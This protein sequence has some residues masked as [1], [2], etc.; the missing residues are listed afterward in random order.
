MAVHSMRRT[1]NREPRPGANR[2]ERQRL[3][4]REKIFEASLEEFRREGFANA[5]IDRIV[6]QAG[7]ARG[8]FYFHFPTKEHV[9]VEAQ[10]RAEIE[11]VER[12]KALGPPP[13][14][15]P[16]FLTRVLETIV[17]SFG[18]DAG[19]RREVLTMYQRVNMNLELSSEPVI[20]FIVDYLADAAERGAIRRDIPPELMAVHFLGSVYTLPT[21][22]DSNPSDQKE[23]IKLTVELFTQGISA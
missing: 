11:L 12:L 16:E 4:T 20:V 19:L 7:V 17:D 22:P 6:E 15:V 5:Q 9:L 23:A 3:E 21:V 14:S 18:E 8:T 2:R 1:A 10:R 13:D